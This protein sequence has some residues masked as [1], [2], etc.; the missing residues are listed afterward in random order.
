MLTN[1]T[2][3]TITITNGLVS[4]VFKLFKDI[5]GG[6]F[7]MIDLYSHEK[8]SSVLRALGPEVILHNYKIRLQVIHISF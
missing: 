6:G 7:V 3:G 8:N 2:D 4:R 5:D 1:D